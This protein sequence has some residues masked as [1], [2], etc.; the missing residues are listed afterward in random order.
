M[1]FSLAKLK[2][3][4]ALLILL[5]CLIE[6]TRSQSND[7]NYVL[8]RTMQD[9]L[10]SL[11]LDRIDYYDGLGRPVQTVLKKASPAQKD[12]VTL[13]EYDA[14][15]RKSKTWLPVPTGATGAYVPLSTVSSISSGFYGDN[16][17]YSKPVYEPSPLGRIEEQYGP[18]SAWHA[19]GKSV[20][21]GW[22]TN[23]AS[24]NLA[25]GL[26]AVASDN[27]LQ[28]KGLYAAGQLYVTRTAD[29]DERISYAFADKFGQTVLQR[30]MNGTVAH[31]TYYIYDK[32]GNLRYVLPP[33]AADLLTATTTWNDDNATL[34]A[35]AYIYK[36]DERRRLK[37][38]KLP[39]AGWAYL[40]YDNQ[41][42]LVLSQ[43]AKLR[44]LNVNKYHYTKYDVLNRPVEQ[45]I[46]VENKDYVVLRGAVGISS[47]YLPVGCSATSYTYYDDY[48]YQSTWG[49]SPIYNTY[50]SVYTGQAKAANVKGLVTGTK[51]KVLETSTWI[52]TVNYYD[53]YGQLIQQFQSNPDGGHNR[54]STAYN[55]TGQPTKQ[56]VYHRR[57]SSSSIV[58][59]D[60]EYF[61]DH[62]GR[63]TRTEYRYN[64]SATPVI[65]VQNTYD[66]IG[67]LATKSQHNNQQY[68]DYRYNIRGW[69]LKLMIPL[70][71]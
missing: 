70:L 27:S 54:T 68:T 45:G 46:C 26:Y 15:G 20:E 8:T 7:R 10:G 14:A 43:D 33:A 63:L 34:K 36:Y 69:L 39:G 59:T 3:T 64:Q 53:K 52:Y 6:E 21:T 1:N 13:Q 2:I 37:E 25:C 24:G 57:T 30:A 5:I 58:Y 44:A 48:N 4:A 29:E 22:L 62:M 49:G 12:I 40:I 50:V 19:T 60:E 32:F 65:L 67:R 9:D 41:D 35:Y 31:D 23:S 56:Q 16:A 28:R 11:A 42:R 61:Y 66:E 18:G 71:L 55:F 17:A 38:K 51:T 47:N